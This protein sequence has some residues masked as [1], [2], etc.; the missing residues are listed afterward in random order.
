MH[1]RLT[2]VERTAGGPSNRVSGIAAK[3][4]GKVS[5]VC[6]LLGGIVLHVLRIEPCRSTQATGPFCV[7]IVAWRHRVELSPVALHLRPSRKTYATDSADARGSKR[8]SKHARHETRDGLTLVLG[9]LHAHAGRWND[10]KHAVS[11]RQLVDAE[12]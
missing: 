10:C 5:A 2:P 6:P 9:A 4:V 3:Q 1:L 12:V 11:P 7:S 8:T